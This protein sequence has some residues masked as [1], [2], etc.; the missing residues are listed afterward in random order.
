MPN[1]VKVNTEK[2]PDE[3]KKVRDITEVIEHQIG[4]DPSNWLD[5]EVLENDLN[6]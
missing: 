2:S 1:M 3:E 6:L 5:E 4:D